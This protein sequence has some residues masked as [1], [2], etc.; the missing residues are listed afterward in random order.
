MKCSQCERPA[1]AKSMCGLHYKRAASTRPA[2]PT[3]DMSADERFDHYTRKTDGCWLWSGGRFGERY[4][5]FY[6]GGR[7]IGAHV[8]SYLR[9][10]GPVPKGWFVCHSCDNPSC[11]NP[12]HLFAAPPKG[13]T[14][15]MMSK[16][17]GRWPRGDG[18][19]LAKL[20]DAQVAEIR[21]LSGAMTQAEIA[22]A[23]GVTQSH[24]SRIVSGHKRGRVGDQVEPLT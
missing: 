9:H 5:A 3:R 2:S 1:L 22:K 6:F 18:H 10:K 11:V 14:D 23:F 16:G 24:V 19:H 15:D 21:R 7:T 17:R 12:G 4:G 8:Y 20:S 13:N